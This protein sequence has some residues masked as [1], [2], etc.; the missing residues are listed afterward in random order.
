[1]YCKIKQ[2]YFCILRYDIINCYSNVFFIDL[3]HFYHLNNTIKILFLIIIIKCIF[4]ILHYN[5][6]IATEIFILLISLIIYSLNNNNN[7]RL[8]KIDQHLNKLYMVLHGLSL[9]LNSSIYWCWIWYFALFQDFLL[10]HWS[11]RSGPTTFCVLPGTVGYDWNTGSLGKS[12][13]G[14]RPSSTTRV[15]G[16]L[17][18]RPLS[19]TVRRVSSSLS[20]THTHVFRTTTTHTPS[21]SAAVLS[22][23]VRPSAN[24]YI[25]NMLCIYKWSYHQAHITYTDCG[26][27]I[28]I[29]QCINE[30]RHT[31]CK[32]GV[33]LM[34][35][36][37]KLILH[38]KAPIKQQDYQPH[39]QRFL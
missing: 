14:R 15:C 28:D 9:F 23:R 24:I 32:C 29:V 7:K 38:Q 11:L 18:D 5:S 1:M 13:D 27:D 25:S 16:Y 20:L 37:Y 26:M 6:I 17:G 33:L 31:Y 22:L 21:K 2:L 4:F 34:H 12:S 39:L 8:N 36:I 10:F 19:C 35:V 3:F 30:S